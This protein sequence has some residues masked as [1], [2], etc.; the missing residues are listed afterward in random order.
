M[1]IV[2]YETQNYEKEYMTKEL[3]NPKIVF[4]NKIFDNKTVVKD[5]DIMSIR[6]HA[7]INKDILNQDQL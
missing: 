4:V 6:T 2:S 1:K 7:Q 3:K 5:A